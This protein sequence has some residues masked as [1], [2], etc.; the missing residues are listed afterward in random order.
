M[1][2]AKIGSNLYFFLTLETEAGEQFSA[3][4]SATGFRP[5]IHIGI[6]TSYLGEL[7][8]PSYLDPDFM[9]MIWKRKEQVNLPFVPRGQCRQTGRRD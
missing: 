5:A 8:F 2:V 1:A 4:V 9:F 6:G 3:G 7:G